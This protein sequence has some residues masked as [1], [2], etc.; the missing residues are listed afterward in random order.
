M[1]N[2][3]ANESSPYLLQHQS[4]PIDWY[5]WCEEAF[6]KAEQED[7]PVFLSIGYSACHWCHVMAHESF[8]DDEVAQMLN[9]HFVSIK[10]D[11]EE[12][13]DID[14]AYM[15]AVQLATGRGGW[16]MSLFLTSAKKP[17]FAG[18]YFPKGGRGRIPG[19]LELCR[20]VCDVWRDQR[21]HAISTSEEFSVGLSNVLAAE[22]PAISG[23]LS[24]KML[25]EGVMALHADFD[26]EHGGFGG[27]P[28]F[29]PHPALSFLLGFADPGKQLASTGWE[30]QARSMALQTIEAMLL[31]GIHDHVGGG[32]H[33][34]STD[35]LWLVPHFEKMLSDNAQLLSLLSRADRGL[36]SSAHCRQAAKR[37]VS[38]IEREMTSPQGLFYS[39]I[40]A[41]SEG[42]EGG[43]I[44]WTTSEIRNLLGRDAQSLIDLYQCRDEGNYHDEASGKLTGQNILHLSQ[45][46]EIDTAPFLDRLLEERLKRPQPEIDIKALACW[47]GMM[48]Q[49]LCEAGRF[50]LAQRCAN[51]WLALE[52]LFG[53]VPHQVVGGRPSGRA[54]LDD[55]AHLA[56]GLY[57]F[58]TAYR[59]DADRISRVM[60]D[61]FYDEQNGG[62][63]F[64]D[65]EH[66]P[67][68][69]RTKPA[70]DGS[71]PSANAVAVRCL[72]ELGDYRRAE[73]CLR[74][75]QSWMVK[76]PRATSALLECLLAFLQS[77]AS[78]EL[79]NIQFELAADEIQIGQDEWARGAIKIE[80][81]QGWHLQ[82]LEIRIDP[83]G[84]AQPVVLTSQGLKGD[85]SVPFHIAQLG[86]AVILI[87][88][89]ACNE[90]ECLRPA[91]ARL[92]VKVVE[93]KEWKS[94]PA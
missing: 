51:E 43:S 44:V 10:V 42:K 24:P 78:D 31:G 13:P 94:P 86:P 16:P 77:G 46:P 56:F 1:P 12:R 93:P 90:R 11:R 47:N 82:T 50:D 76:A 83:T 57:C 64:T 35:A 32:F 49:A 17:F 36:G 41:D 65:L 92:E 19:F 18:T 73:A 6:S 60:I 4:N 80:I 28:K 72:L 5:P 14:E 52:E 22:L 88:Y 39:A 87:D 8:E 84:E 48:I 69:G 38:W 30:D 58:G 2:R 23:E 40:D 21:E 61:R 3:L 62:F 66:E 34:Y 71:S 33:R 54:F 29:P 9:E 26:H 75:F 59:Y 74:Q 91:Q 55:Y 15:T 89:Q 70:L 45:M 79:P 63:F 7:K 20:S 81:P 85:I 25:D 67:L 68:F 27:A 53:E 37:L